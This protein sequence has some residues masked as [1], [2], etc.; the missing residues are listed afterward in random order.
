[1]C[2]D[3]FL[4]RNPTPDFPTKCGG[5]SIATPQFAF[6][7]RP[8]RTLADCHDARYGFLEVFDILRVK[9]VCIYCAWIVFVWVGI[10]GISGIQSEAEFLVF[11]FF[12][13]RRLVLG[14]L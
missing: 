4:P 9:V 14:L 8:V 11:P 10:A 6:D 5:D 13:Y 1:M 3:S 12:V 7:R 2:M